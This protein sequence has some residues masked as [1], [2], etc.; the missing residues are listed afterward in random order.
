M[1][2]SATRTPNVS[3]RARI[4]QV[5]TEVFSEKGFNSTGIEEILLRAKAPKG[6]FY[7]HFKSKEE[8]GLEVISNYEQLWKL[9]L[10]RIFSDKECGPLQRLRNYIEEGMRGMEKYNFK[11]GCLVGNLGQ[12]LGT[13]NNAFRQRIELVFR[14]WSSYV[15]AC[16]DEAMAQNEISALLD[17]KKVARY[18]WTGWEGAILQC[19]LV[20]TVQPLEDFSHVLFEYIL[21][22]EGADVQRTQGQQL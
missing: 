10:D 22:K 19:K 5:G 9:R 4:I 17:S 18:F 12:E 7:H 1:S 3:T 21:H 8:F 15:E 11:R 20:R 2:K 14:H 16:L 13:L 6:V